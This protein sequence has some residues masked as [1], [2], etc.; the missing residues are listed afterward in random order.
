MPSLR[1]I[2]IPIIKCI[3]KTII[4]AISPKK[5][6]FEYLIGTNNSSLTNLHNNI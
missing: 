3:K 4:K 6:N 5:G 2:Q 1:L